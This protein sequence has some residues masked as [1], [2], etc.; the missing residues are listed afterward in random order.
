VASGKAFGDAIETK[1]WQI[2][3]NY[4]KY[5]VQFPDSKSLKG[6]VAEHPVKTSK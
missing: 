1:V 2:V 6:N 5:L 3:G 4:T